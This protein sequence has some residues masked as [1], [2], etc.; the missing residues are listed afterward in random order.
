MPKDRSD[1]RY[2]QEENC[3]RLSRENQKRNSRKNLEHRGIRRYFY[4]RQDDS[5]QRF[6]D[7]VSL[8]RNAQKEKERISALAEECKSILER[9]GAPWPNGNRRGVDY[10][11]LVAGRQKDKRQSQDYR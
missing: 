8:A 9:T 3:K 1:P 6:T 11:D 4:H 5:D 7:H 2:W 10:S